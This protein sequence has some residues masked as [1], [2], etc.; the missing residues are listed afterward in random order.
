MRRYDRVTVSVDANPRQLSRG[1]E[2]APTAADIMRFYGTLMDD[3]PYESLSVTMLE[4]DLPG[5][6]SPAYFAII[7]NAAP[8]SKLYWGNDPAAFAGVPEYFLPPPLVRD[9]VGQE[10]FGDAGERG[11]IVSPIE[12]RERR[13]VVDDGEVR[14][15]VAARQIVL[16]H[17]HAQ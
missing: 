5:G 8:F 1:R 2:T 9:L 17:R 11:G 3:T 10:V 6:H 7:N 4:H 15:A 13:G 14:G 12:L 16:E